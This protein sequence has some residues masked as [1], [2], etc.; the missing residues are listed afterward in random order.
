MKVEEQKQAVYKA[1]DDL[2]PRLIDISKQIHGHPETNFEEYFASDLLS[3]TAEEAGFEVERQIAE[4]DTA[5]KAVYRGKHNCPVV[6]FLSEYDALPEVGHACGHNLIGT[7]GLGAA[8]AIATAF[9]TLPGTVELIGTPAEEGGGGK[10]LLADRGV[11]DEVDAAM[12]FHPAPQNQLWKYAMASRIVEIEFFGKAAHA[13]SS[14]EKGINALDAVIQTFNNINALRQHMRTDVRV[15]GIILDGGKAPNIVPDHSSALFYVRSLDD[16]YCSQM[17][18]KVRGCAAGAASATGATL[19]FHERGSA[20]KTLKTNRPLTES[21]QRN[22]E[23]MGVLFE[24][25]EPMDDIG[26]TDMGNVSHITPSIHPYLEIGGSSLIYHSKEFA[27]A[28]VSEKGHRT[29]ILAAKAMAATAV[30]FFLDEHFRMQ[31]KRDFSRD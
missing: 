18:E 16:D 23:S 19:D 4:V 28:A 17:V 27:E 8:L 25:N 6:A 21:F 26:S 15:H 5:F 3:K 14:P 13:A 31:V 29:M 11:F 2:T 12:M 20:Y 7:A 9:D 22:I 24:E 1:L 30:E 10:I